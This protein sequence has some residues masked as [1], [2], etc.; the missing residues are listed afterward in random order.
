MKQN[1][2]GVKLTVSE[3]TWSFLLLYFALRLSLLPLYSVYLARK[4]SSGT[5]S[6]LFC[7]FL[8]F[9][10][11]NNCLT[12]IKTKAVITNYT[13]NKNAFRVSELM[14]TIAPRFRS[15][16]QGTSSDLR[17]GI[18]V[19]NRKQ[20]SFGVLIVKNAWELII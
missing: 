1:K 20:E 2:F 11:V 13:S 5:I 14:Q 8:F 15:Q 6:L 17:L 7:C 3:S 16:L 19:S 18:A 9:F 12:W 10:I 4:T